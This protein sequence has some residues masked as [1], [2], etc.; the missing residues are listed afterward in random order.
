[1]FAAAGVTAVVFD[2]QDVGTRFYTSISTLYDS[3]VAAAR[4]GLRYLVLD[5]P[6]PIGGRAYTSGVGRKEIVQQHGMTAGELARL[7]DGEFLPAEGAFD[8]TRYWIDLLTCS[9]RLRT[10]IDAGA[11][12]DEVAGELA[13]FDRRRRPYLLY[14]RPGS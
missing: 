2:I 9:G 1:M 10:M 7:Y 5:R 13:A 6:N 14:S 12:A 11:S 3:M 8:G 4:L